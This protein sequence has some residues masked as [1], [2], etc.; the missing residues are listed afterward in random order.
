[1][2]TRNNIENDQT[3]FCKKSKN[4]EN[5]AR[6]NSLKSKL[7]FLINGNQKKPNIHFQK[8]TLKAREDKM[9]LFNKL[10]EI[11]KNKINAQRERNQSKQF[12]GS[13]FIGKKKRISENKNPK[14]V[15]FN[16]KTCAQSNEKS[17]AT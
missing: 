2:K 12:C 11:G 17:M 13:S 5:K 1:M 9:I 4:S 3:E 10:N 16:K 15:S 8:I 6:N 7:N 14:N